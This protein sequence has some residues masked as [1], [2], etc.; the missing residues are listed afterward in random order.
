MNAQQLI[1]DI[2]T[3][4]TPDQIRAVNRVMSAF[5][6][7]ASPDDAKAVRTEFALLVEQTLDEIDQ[8]AEETLRFLALNGKRYNLDEWLTPAEYAKQYGLRSVNNV[9]NW[10]VRGIIPAVDILEV[11]ELNGLRLVRN[12]PYRETSAEVDH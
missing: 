8:Q 12:K 10:M 4:Q 7:T 11:P 3:A 2:N 1:Q 5:L 6:S 9:T